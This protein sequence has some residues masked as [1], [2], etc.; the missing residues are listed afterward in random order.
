MDRSPDNRPRGL[1]GLV[2]VAGFFYRHEA[3]L[4]RGVL[5]ANGIDAVVM[6]D[7]T[8]G[9][10]PGL[11]YVLGAHVLV[12]PGDAPLARRILEEGVAAGEGQV[13]PDDAEPSDPEMPSDP[14]GL[15]N[16][17]EPSDPAGLSDLAEQPDPEP[18][19]RSRMATNGS[20]MITSAKNARIKRVLALID[21]RK[22]RNRTKL[23]PV[24]GVRA[25]NGV[26]E[27]NWRVES[28]I[29]C[30]ERSQTRWAQGIIERTDPRLHLPV[31]EY[32]MG[33]I[34]QRTEASELVAVVEQ[35]PDDLQRVAVSDDLLAVL[36]DR[37]QNPGN[38]GSLIRSCEALGASALLII[39]H[40]VDL[41]A[42]RTVRA[43]MGA[44]FALPV[45]RLDGLETLEAW[46]AGV[47]AQTGRFE[48][49]GTSA[50]AARTAS[51]HPWTGP[52]L[53]VVGNEMLGMSQRLA[54]MCGISVTI[55]MFGSSSSLNVVAATSILLY[56]ARRQ[57]RK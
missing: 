47:R 1:G 16:P 50:H 33:R 36:V 29:Y 43:S 18:P 20:A 41:Y 27:H 34:S 31:N 56:E 2:E 24:E 52:T 19:A 51:E 55:P 40:A 25:I 54:A 8:G 7:D 35:A 45:I 15:S 12:H 11:Q 5:A 46:I 30:P 44:F 57:R 53:L 21:R 38:L 28:L 48:L 22:A 39:G 6:S 17:A 14:A 13:S 37:P 32:L 3:E 9:Q 49:V 26:Y 23:F 4:A 10:G 42:P